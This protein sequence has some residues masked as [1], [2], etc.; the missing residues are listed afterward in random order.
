M[1]EVAAHVAD[2]E[3]ARK[4]RPEGVAP[5]H[6]DA[7]GA[8]EVA[9]GLAAVFDRTPR[10]SRGPHAGAQHPPRLDRAHAKHLPLWAVGGDARLGVRRW[11]EA[12]PRQ[13]PVLDHAADRLV[14]VV[15]HVL[16]PRVVE[17][18]AVLRAAGLRPQVERSRIEG[19]VATRQIDD[20][21]RIRPPHAAPGRARGPVDAVVGRE[22][23]RVQQPLHVV[24][25]EAREHRS[26]HL[27]GPVAV[28]VL[29]VEDV[30]GIAHEQAAVEAAQC[31]RPGQARPAAKISARS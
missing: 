14:A 15:A 19:E 30:G 1:H 9:G 13:E 31:G 8:R 20:G 22:R 5:D 25:T 21:F 3:H 10:Q 4:L 11:K 23:E 7:R 28:D 2:H 12:I 18:Q 26:P 24:R 17:R 6:G 27:R 16:A 29:Q